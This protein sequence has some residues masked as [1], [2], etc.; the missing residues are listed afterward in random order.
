MLARSMS[1]LFFAAEMVCPNR[2]PM[3]GSPRTEMGPL[4]QPALFIHRYRIPYSLRL[5][6]VFR[7]ARGLIF[8]K[9]PVSH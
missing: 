4:A 5:L 7:D 8:D 6:S 1:G 3:S 2:A 9:F